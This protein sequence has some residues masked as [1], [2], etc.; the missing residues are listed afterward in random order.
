MLRHCAALL[1]RRP[2]L[3]AL[4][5]LTTILAAATEAASVILLL[6]LLQVAPENPVLANV[7]LVDRTQTYF[8]ALDYPTRIKTVAIAF[9]LVCL[10]RGCLTFASPA[11][12]L[13]MPLNVERQLRRQALDGLLHVRLGYINARELGDLAMYLGT[14]PANI[15]AS[16][17]Q[18]ATA[19]TFAMFLSVNIIIMTLLSWRLTMLAIIAMGMISLI[20]RTM[21]GARIR[22]AGED[23]VD[24]SRST[25]QYIYQLLSA[26]RLIRLSTAE[27]K[28]SGRFSGA[29][30]GLHQAQ[31]RQ[32][33]L[34]VAV[35]PLMTTLVGLLIA[36]LLLVSLT[37]P[38][39]AGP[40]ALPV[41]LVF[42]YLLSRLM[43]P[44]SGLNACRARLSAFTPSFERF[45][46]F[47]SETRRQRETDGGQQFTALA[48]SVLLRDVTF[49][50]GKE[51]AATLKGVDLD[52]RRGAVT[53]LVGPSGGGKSTIVS[54]ITRIHEPTGGE[55]LADGVPLSEYSLSSWRGRLAVVD[56][57][58]VILN[59]TVRENVALGNVAYT[60]EEIRDALRAAGASPFVE[61]LPRGLDTILGERGVRLSSGQQQRLAIARALLRKPEFLMLDEATN[62]LDS[63]TEA[64]IQ[65]SIDALRGKVTVL[66]VAHRLASIKN[67][68]K[69]SVIEAGRVVESGSHDELTAKRGRYSE[70][71]RQQQLVAERREAKE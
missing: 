11:L 45:E 71:L 37:S 36:S 31:F 18:L 27:Q 16:T 67:A 54:L 47:I 58:N 48:E 20:V 15:A 33:A 55:V 23:V 62:N 21:T 14:H 34:E 8:Y 10:V 2:A 61:E 9:A 65:E 66:I 68:D 13:R 12:S 32:G 70:L 7:P 30:G 69:I 39:L 22:A 64:T 56:Q 5:V 6:P 38:G 19:F 51:S 40:E 3:P 24:A 50:Y 42:M 43:A 46:A 53:A 59:D 26:A 52:I 4:F 28:V 63:I 49:T 41:V 29:V 25:G 35:G 44:V 57:D 1:W 60:D 17:Q